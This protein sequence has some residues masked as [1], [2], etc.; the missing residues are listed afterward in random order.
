M[1]ELADCDEITLPTFLV[2]GP[3]VAAL[4]ARYLGEVVRALWKREGT[5]LGRLHC[6][7]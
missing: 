4:V 1:S 2:R 3:Y 7:G 6:S 5:A